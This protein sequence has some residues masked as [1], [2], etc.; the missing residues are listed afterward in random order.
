M[1]NEGIFTDVLFVLIKERG[2]THHVE[3]DY[4]I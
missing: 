2:N 1:N 3:K 4:K